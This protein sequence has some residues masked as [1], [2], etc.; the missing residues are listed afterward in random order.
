MDR[1]K[2]FILHLG[3]LYLSGGIFVNPWSFTS[4]MNIHRVGVILL[5]SSLR[6]SFVMFSS[7]W[8]C[9]VCVVS[10][11]VTSLLYFSDF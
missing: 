8:T 9:A 11:V 3:P 6:M 4:L 5:V 1:M 2:S 10:S 7:L